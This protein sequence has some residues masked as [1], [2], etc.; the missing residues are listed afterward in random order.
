MA[1]VYQAYDHRLKVWRAVK[2]LL[3]EY[4]KRKKIRQRFLTEA[5]AMA[6][7]EHRHIV[8]VYDV[9]EDGADC[10][11]IM[12]LVDGGAVEDWLERNGFMPPRLAVKC[13]LDMC[14]GIGIAHSM[15]I[16]HRDIK[17][18]NVLVDRAGVCKVTDFG[19][20]QLRDDDGAMTRTGT[21][22][23]TLG[24]MAP[25]QRSDSKSIDERADIYSLGASLF[26]MLTSRTSMDLFAADRDTTILEGIDE[27]L[28]EVISRATRY[29]PE[30]RYANTAEMAQA[31]TEA[32]DALPEDPPDTPKL[33]EPDRAIPSAPK[34]PDKTQETFVSTP[35]P[36]QRDAAAPAGQLR[37]VIPDS[38]LQDQESRDSDRDPED[39]TLYKGEETREEVVAG[40]EDGFLKRLWENAQKAALLILGYLI[41][42]GFVFRF[43]LP[44]SI[45]CVTMGIWLN[46]TA[47]AIELA[48]ADWRNADRVFVEAVFNGAPELDKQL[49]AAGV[50]RG[51]TA[52]YRDN[53]RVAN[54]FDK[55]RDAAN[56]YLD[57][58]GGA[59]TGVRTIDP[60]T[61]SL[62][63]KA[64]GSIEG[65]EQKRTLSREALDTYLE[66]ASSRSAEWA[67][68]LRL[69]ERPPE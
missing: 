22:M 58:V 18:H 62:V 29:A 5:Q 38:G 49:E 16:I 67:M 54:T 11:I 14:E 65:L 33:A 35:A 10:Y 30:E 51:V 48:A 69:V 43:L 4:V 12:E 19:I 59:L 52:S 63:R 20:A 39:G 1:Q 6:R 45:I 55:Q 57:A 60:A 36:V 66:V 15:G 3:P 40:E 68:S 25:E 28:C 26:T 27:A 64:R 56:S 42:E 44:L 7:L 53:M 46:L 2:I 13:L 32:L 34:H 50:R 8:R 9:G 37:E 47:E 31:L 17:P 23:G 61:R 21:V 24:Y 41:G